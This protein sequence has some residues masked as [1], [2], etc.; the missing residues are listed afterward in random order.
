V[1][2]YQ[3][4]FLTVVRYGGCAQGTLGC[5]GFLARR[6]TNLQV[7][8]ATFDRLVAIVWLLIFES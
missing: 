8:A 1:P 2:L 5:A 7:T 6:S 3:Q 4:P